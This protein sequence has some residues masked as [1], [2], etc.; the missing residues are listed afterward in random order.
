M[1]N[2]QPHTVGQEVELK[3][4]SIAHGGISVAR[5]NGRVIFVADAIPGEKVVAQVTESRKKSFAR[6]ATTRVIEASPDRVEHVWAE[7]SLNQPIDERVGGAEFGHITLKRQR[8]L[9]SEVLQDAMQRFGRIEAVAE[10]EAAPGDDEAL[11]LGWRSR[12]RLHVDQETGI[13]GPYAA[14]SRRVIKVDALPLANEQINM[15]APLGEFMPD[16]ETIDVVAPSADDPRSLFT[17][18]GSRARAGE[19]DAVYETVGDLQF[20]VSAGGFWQVHRE[21]PLVLYNAV[22]ET[23]KS[24][25]DNFDPQAANL[26]LYGGVGLFARA[27]LDVGGAR[28][29]ITSVESAS[30]ATDFAAENLSDF[31]GAMAVTERVDKYL[32]RLNTLEGATVV[33]DPPRSGAGLDVTQKLAALKPQNLIYVACDPVALSRDTAALTDLGYSMKSLRGYDLF[34]HTHHFECIA[35]FQR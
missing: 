17:Y 13:V 35:V 29:K 31:I 2:T 34:P 14:R 21:A 7:A 20:M 30:R 4:E 12:V 6:A 9:K 32:K 10:I 27:V 16:V 28:T 1:T 23:V 8:Q 33:L 19:N 3:I 22:H 11:G 15:I 26:D 25:A 18:P 5:H 24:L